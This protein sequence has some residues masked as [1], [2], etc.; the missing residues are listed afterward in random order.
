MLDLAPLDHKFNCEEQPM[1]TPIIE[2]DRLRLR[3]FRHDDLDRLAEILRDPD[4]MRY[5]PGAKP[6]P[7]ERAEANLRNIMAHWER[8]GF[9]WW[10]VDYRPDDRLIGW[11]GLGIVDELDATEVAYLFDS[12]Y[13]RKG[14][15]TEA[16]HVS[17][18]YGFEELN[19]EHVIALAHTENI[20]SQR[21]MKKNGMEFKGEL[22]LWGLDLAQ[23]DIARDQ[24]QPDDTPYALHT[25]TQ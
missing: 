16:A 20:A 17:L 13:W 24:F 3:G 21:V 19:L 7:R 2:T 4:V 8:H 11:C 15:A 1:Q 12:P 5:M 9:G 14:I 18:R 23:Y 25:T 6:M 10:A 22:H